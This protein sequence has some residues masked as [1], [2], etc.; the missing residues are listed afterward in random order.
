MTT[1]TVLTVRK[2]LD[3]P[4]HNPDH[5]PERSL[6]SRP[7]ATADVV[8]YNVRMKH[9]PGLIVVCLAAI[10]MLAT[11][12]GKH[13]KVDASEQGKALESASSQTQAEWKLAVEA[14]KTNDYA[15]AYLM[16]RKLQGQTDLTPEQHTAV[17]AKLTQVN[18]AMLAAVQK[19]D[20]EA[21]KAFDEIKRHW[22]SN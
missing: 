10:T 5:L 4:R 16:L 20:P 11:G 3:K 9:L 2:Q 8:I 19:G 22:R 12:C 13:A 6:P 17:D 1:L 7:L 18:D 15:A 14:A 21:K